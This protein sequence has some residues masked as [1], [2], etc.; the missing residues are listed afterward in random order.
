MSIDRIAAA[1]R[2]IPDFPKPGIIYK[3]I[4]PLLK[5]PELFKE[6]IRALAGRCTEKPDYIA[7]IEARGF[8]IG[9]PLALEL[10]C[11]FIPVRKKGKL[12]YATVEQSYSLEYGTASIEIHQDAV[13]PGDKVL[14]VD[15]VLATGGTA[16]AAFELLKKINAEIIGINFLLELSFLMGRDKLR[17]MKVDSL[18]TV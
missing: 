18:I 12:P 7:G 8:I 6:T 11:G 15:D 9:A 5:D 16:V 3:D 14:I 17:E 4:T 2:D 10:G 1:I 13:K